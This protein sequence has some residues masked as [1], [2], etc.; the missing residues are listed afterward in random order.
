[1]KSLPA[2]A[3]ALVLSLSTASVGRAIIAFDDFESDPPY[4]T[5]SYGDNGGSNFGPLTYLEGTGG[6]IYGETGAARIAGNRSLGI[7]ANSGAGNAQALG[8][9]LTSSYSTG[10]YEVALRFNL[11]G[12]V[13]FSGVN[14]K[15]ANLTAS[16]AGAFGA[17]ELLAIG[18]VPAGG[19]QTLRLFGSSNLTLDFGTE[20]RGSIIA[21]RVDFDAGAGTYTAYAGLGLG[22]YSLST[23]GNL[24]ASGTEVRSLGFAN[25]NTGTNQD[26]IVD[27]VSIPEP[28]AALGLLGGFGVLALVRRRQT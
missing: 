4:G 6:G 9:N 24:K 11:N 16:G 15:S 3:I 17:N 22:N 7:F 27:N 23:S 14:L 2:C 26:L 13:G 20:I 1:M 25:F 10:R 5:V 28:S 21:L 19:N 18:L 12:S 8:R